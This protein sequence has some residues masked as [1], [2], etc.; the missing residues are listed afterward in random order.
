MTQI[1]TILK[2]IGRFVFYLVLGWGV[3][4]VVCL[5]MWLLLVVPLAFF[6]FFFSS[7]NKLK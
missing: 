7:L 4:I 1:K 3:I 5:L 6:D 2:F